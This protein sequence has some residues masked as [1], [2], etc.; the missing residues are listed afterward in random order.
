MRRILRVYVYSTN[1]VAGLWSR[2]RVSDINQAELRLTEADDVVYAG[3]EMHP[4]WTFDMEELDQRL[5]ANHAVTY[6]EAIY[7]AINE[8]QTEAGQFFVDLDTEDDISCCVV[9]WE[10]VRVIETTTDL[11]AAASAV[12]RA[13][14][15]SDGCDREQAPATRQTGAVLRKKKSESNNTWRVELLRDGTLEYI[16]TV[17][18][19]E[20]A[21]ALIALLDSPR[22]FIAAVEGSPGFHIRMPGSLIPFMHELLTLDIR[23]GVSTVPGGLHF[24]HITAGQCCAVFHRDPR[25][26]PLDTPN[27]IVMQA[28]ATSEEVGD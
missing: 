15:L 7:A 18:D 6:A 5:A 23:L 3:G 1:L 26:L 17:A 11:T 25:V 22:I 28:V 13:A 12:T 9:T 4:G 21:D 19:E 2:V 24:R 8:N 27:D 16:G 10:V 14:A 20:I